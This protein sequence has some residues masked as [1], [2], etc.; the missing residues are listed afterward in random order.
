MRS[1]VAA[2]CCYYWIRTARA[3]GSPPRCS[4]FNTERR[5]RFI[6][7]SV[8]WAAP[9]RL[10]SVGFCEE[11]ESYTCYIVYLPTFY[12]LSKFQNWFF[13]VLDHDFPVMYTRFK[14]IAWCSYRRVMAAYQRRANSWLNL[15]RWSFASLQLMANRALIQSNIFFNQIFILKMS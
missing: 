8:L 3:L 2:S 11:F 14:Y 7:K 5:F 9:C 4:P 1:V 15:A 10:D 12:F 13:I 6:S